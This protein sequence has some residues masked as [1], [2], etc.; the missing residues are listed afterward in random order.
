[1][2][3]SLSRSSSRENLMSFVT[4]RVNDWLRAF[5]SQ[6]GTSPLLK[7]IAHFPFV[8]SMNNSSMESKRANG[9]FIYHAIAKAGK[10]KNLHL[11]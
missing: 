6:R 5:F 3:V 7:V 1:M 9:A 8:R 2:K 4:E 10:E 11:K